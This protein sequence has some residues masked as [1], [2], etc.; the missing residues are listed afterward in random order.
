MKRRAF[1]S[2]LT[3]PWAAAATRV[4]AQASTAHGAP[5]IGQVSRDSVW[6][7][8]PE[9]MIHRMLQLADTTRGDLV[10]DLGSGDGRVPIYAARH[11]GARAIGI[12]LE[13]NLVRLAQRSARDQGVSHRVRFLRQDLFEADIS[14]ASVIAL[15][16]SPGGMTKLKPRLL[17]Q[18]PGTRVVSHQF[19][20]DD[21]EPDEIVRVEGRTGYLWVVPA[22][23]RGA[24]TISGAGEE[25]RVHI[26]QKHQML[27]TRGERGGR[28]VNVI[29]ARL[30]GNQI[31]FT[32][33]DR[34]GAS[35]R[36]AGRLVGTAL[37]GAT[38]ADSGLSLRWRG[39][40]T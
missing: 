21:W 32:S 15:Y 8:T 31:G 23:V 38:T 2:G 1:I 11:F 5:Q 18:K 19:H 36:Y 24:W 10:F 26:G 13:D 39:T 4:L 6:V 34:D 25:L 27:E 14:R 28:P 7:P 37:V 16:L 9:R 40:Q 35:V 17:A 29:G 3:L 22:D 12:E 20:L 33:F 30:R